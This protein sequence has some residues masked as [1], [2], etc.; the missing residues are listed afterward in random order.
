ML[1]TFHAIVDGDPPP[2]RH[3]VA[4]QEV[5]RSNRVLL[6]DLDRSVVQEQPRLQLVVKV[7]LELERNRF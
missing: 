5:V 2:N 1:H 6:E 4:L 3:S 7:G